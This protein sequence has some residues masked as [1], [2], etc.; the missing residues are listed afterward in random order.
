MPK[1]VKRGGKN[2][3]FNPLKI[4]TSV[5]KAAHE[6][7]L[8]PAQIG[9]L[10]QDIAEPVIQT[11]SKK[12]VVKTTELRKSLLGRLDRKAKK[13]SAAWRRYDAKVKKK[14]HKG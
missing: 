2:E 3:R 10:V 6:A 4:K 13:V 5:K 8:A 1:V 12:E 11:F 14:R 9:D 7:G